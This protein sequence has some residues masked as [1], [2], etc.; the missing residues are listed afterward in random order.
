MRL[1]QRPPLS[2]TNSLPEAQTT[3][4]GGVAAG[5]RIPYLLP[6]L[7]PKSDWTATPD[8]FFTHL[9]KHEDGSVTKLVAQVIFRTWGQFEDKKRQTRVWEWPVTMGVLHEVC[10]IKSRTSLYTAI[11]DARAKGYVIQRQLTDPEELVVFQERYGYKPV[12][13]LRLRQRDDEL[14]LPTT[15]RPGYGS[16]ASVQ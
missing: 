4:N 15:P 6:V 12:F 3:D 16:R 5:Q 11:W 7:T 2:L 9:A 13:T 1:Y 8:T 14:D 10:G